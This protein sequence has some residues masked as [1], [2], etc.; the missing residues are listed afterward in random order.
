MTKEIANIITLLLKDLSYKDIL[1][2]LAQPVI[3]KKYT[4]D[5]RMPLA[6]KMPVTYDV[7]GHKNTALG[8]ER[9][10][11]PNQGK[12]SIIYCEDFG[13]SPDPRGKA[14][15][16]AQITNIRVVAWLNKQ[17]MGLGVH[18]EITAKCMR[19]MITQICRGSAINYQGIT[20]LFFTQGRIL[21]QNA[22]IFSRYN[23]DEAESQYLRPPFEYFA[24]D[25]QAKYTVIG[26][27][28]MPA[29]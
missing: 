14:G 15:S 13:T 3:D 2:G 21:I 26:N 10:L 5:S 28:C 29:L 1:A 11:V 9:E 27:G 6:R 17:K 16:M 12:K 7:T 25:F 19:E 24:I 20:R 22:E 18:D 23:Y 8:M 4:D